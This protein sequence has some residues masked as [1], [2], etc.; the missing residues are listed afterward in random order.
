M[1]RKGIVIINEQHKLLP[2]QEAVL[3]QEGY[4]DLEELRVPAQGWT[5]NE[6][7]T[8]ENDLFDRLKEGVDVIFI[9]PVPRLIKGLSFKAGVLVGEG[10]PNRLGTVRVFHNDRR[11][12]KELP[13][14]RIIYTVAKDGWTLI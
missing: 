10:Y 14:G 9:S 13:D 11:E 1:E 8:V 6:L 3:R 4:R 7:E 2:Q 12:K 5:I